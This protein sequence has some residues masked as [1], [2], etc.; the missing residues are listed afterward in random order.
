MHVIVIAIYRQVVVGFILDDRRVVAVDVFG[1]VV[2]VGDVGDI[3]DACVAYVDVA[4]IVPARCV[5][6]EVRF[7]ITQREPSHA[8]AP[9]KGQTDT[10]ATAADPGHQSRRVHRAHEYRSGDPG[11]ISAVVHP[12]TVVAGRKSP[13]SVINPSPTPRLEP[14]PMSVMIR[15]PARR[16]GRYPDG[17]VRG[18]DP[19]HSVVVEIFGSNHVWGNIARG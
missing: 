6:G 19:P 9:T 12:T 10:P 8:A 3:R 17:P 7:T 13:R 5:S 4:E 16:Y 14:D 2:I 1:V 18:H 15:S 11:P